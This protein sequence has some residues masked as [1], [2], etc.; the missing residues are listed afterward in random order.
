MLAPENSLSPKIT[1]NVVTLCLNGEFY[2]RENNFATLSK[3][4]VYFVIRNCSEAYTEVRDQK[5]KVIIIP[6]RRKIQSES[7]ERK[8]PDQRNP[9]SRFI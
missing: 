2:S 3:D 5:N 7:G 9:F 6:T 4:P 1:S 8:T